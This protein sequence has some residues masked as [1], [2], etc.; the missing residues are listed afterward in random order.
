MTSLTLV[1][2]YAKIKHSLGAG[3]DY[4]LRSRMQINLPA[5]I[6]VD[7]G[8]GS[9][10]TSTLIS[11]LEKIN[12]WH[13]LWLFAKNSKEPLYE[14]LVESWEK[15]GGEVLVSEDLADLPDLSSLTDDRP[16]LLIIDDM[17]VEKS[18]KQVE[19]MFLRGRRAGVT[20]VMMTQRF[21]ALPLMIRS[22]ATV[23][24]LKRLNSDKALR[25]ILSEYNMNDQDVVN[26]YKKSIQNPLDFFMIDLE[27]ND[28]RLR[29]RHNFGERSERS[30]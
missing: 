2:Q 15:R 30:R 4:S 23:I 5:R 6:L 10:K 16:T 14:K 21:F 26:V 27:T 20:I 13:R 3:S 8:S 18:L 9:R 25:R 28:P 17:I 22:N 24:I 29:V 1:D 11:I 7:G 12:A 19:T